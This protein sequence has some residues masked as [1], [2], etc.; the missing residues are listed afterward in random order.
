[1]K[2]LEEASSG[3]VRQH[4]LVGLVLSGEGVAKPDPARSE[5]RVDCSG[6]TVRTKRNKMEKQ[7]GKK[8][9]REET[10]K[11]GKNKSKRDLKYLRALSNLPV[12]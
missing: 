7:E 2:A 12:R 8:K 6:F 3:T 10:S 11:K 9:V 5:V 1:M 4:R